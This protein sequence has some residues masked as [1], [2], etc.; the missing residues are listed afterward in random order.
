VSAIRAAFSCFRFEID[1]RNSL[2]YRWKSSSRRRCIRIASSKFLIIA[3]LLSKSFIAIFSSS[4]CTSSISAAISALS[5][6]S[7]MVRSK[8]AFISSKFQ[9]LSD[10]V[11]MVSSREVVSSMISFNSCI[12]AS[13]VACVCRSSSNLF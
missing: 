8:L 2:T 13:V 12:S 10:K 3:S 5:S 11:S 1:V 6:I 7:R 4:L 9:T